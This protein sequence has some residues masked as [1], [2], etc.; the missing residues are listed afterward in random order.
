MSLQLTYI[1]ISPHSD[2]SGDINECQLRSVSFTTVMVLRGNP[3][4]NN[5]AVCFSGM[6]H[7]NIDDNMKEIRSNPEACVRKINSGISL[8]TR[9]YYPYL[10]NC[11]CLNECL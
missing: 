2:L 4:Y 10:P 3:R 1:R 5:V 11:I 7:Q 8:A 9:E 6:K